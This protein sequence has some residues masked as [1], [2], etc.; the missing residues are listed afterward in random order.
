M[1]RLT[2]LVLTPLLCACALAPPAVASDKTENSSACKLEEADLNANRGLTWQQFDQQA[3]IRTSWRSLIERE[4]YDAAVRAYTDYLARGVVPS[5]ERWQTTARFHLGQS[6]AYA[7]HVEE[8]ARMIAT[9]RRETEIGEQRWNLYV[10]G[11][12]AF[13]IR[14]REGLAS[15]FRELKSQ[16]GQSNAI[17]AGVLS[18]LLHCFDKPYRIAGA[19]ACVAASGYSM[20]RD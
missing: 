8:A 15:A 19:P 4:C 6:L 13:L 1:R 17:N 9:A 18:G 2:G 20:P 10:Q 3:Q 7:G 11:T 14:D 12:Y 5:S 16:P